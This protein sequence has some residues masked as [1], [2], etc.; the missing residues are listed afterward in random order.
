MRS[1]NWCMKFT[2][3]ICISL[4]FS[5]FHAVAMPVSGLSDTHKEVKTHTIKLNLEK[6]YEHDSLH[7]VVG[8]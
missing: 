2:L 6:Y 4:L 7:G 3:L 5:M 8:G 1:Y